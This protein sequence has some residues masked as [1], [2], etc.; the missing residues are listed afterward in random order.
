M[1]K[2]VHLVGDHEW[3]ARVRRRLPG[4]EMTEVEVHKATCLLQIINGRLPTGSSIP[5][6]MVAMRSHQDGKSHA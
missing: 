2:L 6:T 3:I 1:I 5:I 4:V